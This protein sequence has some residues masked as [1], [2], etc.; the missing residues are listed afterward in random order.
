MSSARHTAKG[1][2]RGVATRPPRSG[3]CA[4]RPKPKRPSGLAIESRPESV[5]SNPGRV[6]AVRL[7][8]ALRPAPA[9]A[10][11]DAGSLA[12]VPPPGFHPER[13]GAGRRQQPPPRDRRP[14]L[15]AAVDRPN[16]MTHSGTGRIG[17]PAR[18]G[19]RSAQRAA[20]STAQTD[21]RMCHH[22]WSAVYP[23]HGGSPCEGVERRG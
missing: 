15:A 10:L 22:R 9:R 21:A 19:P 7:S 17:E 18:L 3:T 13:G 20:R 16:K 8:P 14:P 1:V 12:G 23:R 5:G 4:V 2:S 11:Y 6:P